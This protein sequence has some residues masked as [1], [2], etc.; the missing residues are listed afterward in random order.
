M[1]ARVNLG[2]RTDT[3]CDKLSTESPF[4]KTS[5]RRANG[6]MDRNCVSPNICNNS[7]KRFTSGRTGYR[8]WQNS[9]KFPSTLVTEVRYEIRLDIESLFLHLEDRLVSNLLGGYV[10]LFGYDELKNLPSM[11]DYHDTVVTASG[12]RRKWPRTTLMWQARA[13]RIGLRD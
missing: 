8:S 10:T 11:I 9:I 5:K 2:R 1:R 13:T 12:L 7:P 4:A 3:V 6:L